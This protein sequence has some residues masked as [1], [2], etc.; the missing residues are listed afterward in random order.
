MIYLTEKHS[1]KWRFYYREF[2]IDVN[3]LRQLIN[4]R[5]NSKLFRTFLIFLEDTSKD[6][7]VLYLCDVC[8]GINWSG[9][10]VVQS[11]AVS[12]GHL[13][14]HYWMTWHN[15]V[16]YSCDSSTINEIGNYVVQSLT[17]VSGDHLQHL[18]ILEN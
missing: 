10:Y 11:L 14:A 5:N 18:V 13:V 3:T 1:R 7:C 12:G 9:N 17:I 15:F 4:I 6:S 2:W 8:S 16:L